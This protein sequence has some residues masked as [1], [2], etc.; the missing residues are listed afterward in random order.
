MPLVAGADRKAASRAATVNYGCSQ[1]TLQ[2][3]K[4]HDKV[5]G[6]LGFCNN[7]VKMLSLVN[8]VG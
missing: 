4:K 5:W 2:L 7:R 8:E 1:Y 3:H 6:N